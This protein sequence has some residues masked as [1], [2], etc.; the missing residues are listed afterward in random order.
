MTNG[1]RSN[2]RAIMLALEPELYGRIQQTQAEFKY[3]ISQ[4][5]A[6]YFE[7]SSQ[8][9]PN[10]SPLN[11]YI[12]ALKMSIGEY[13]E[14]DG[15][16]FHGYSGGISQVERALTEIFDNLSGSPSGYTREDLQRWEGNFTRFSKGDKFT[17]RTGETRL[18]TDGREKQLISVCP[19]SSIAKYMVG[20]GYSLITNYLRENS[21]VATSEP[22]P[23]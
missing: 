17:L 19:A 5:L 3:H 12:N 4:V 16:M 15:E 22:S 7:D 11:W 9:N 10:D 6:L 2:N 14:G 23:T 18:D 13:F 20:Q 1:I 21:R 8:G